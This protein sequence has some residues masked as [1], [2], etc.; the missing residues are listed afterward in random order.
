VVDFTFIGILLIFAGI[1]VVALSFLAPTMK[2]GEVKGAA[3]V[4]VGPI[5][6]V[7]GSDAKW[8]SLALALAIILT[9]LM[10]VFYLV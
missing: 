5:P 7:F 10:V 1:A 3:V 4:M 6:I 8:A 2:A 9:V